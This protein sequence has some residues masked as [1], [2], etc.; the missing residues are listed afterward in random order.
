MK[1][2]DTTTHADYLAHLNRYAT[3]HADNLLIQQSLKEHAKEIV[4]L[5]TLSLDPIRDTLSDLY[6]PTGQGAPRDPTAMF[7]AWLTMTLTK[8]GSPTN[9]VKTTR[10]DPVLATLAGFD[11]LDTP[12]VGTYYDFLARFADGPYDLRRSQDVT[13]S[14]YLRGRHSRRLSDQ[15]TARQEDA[16]DFTSQSEKLSLDLLNTTDRPRDP[17]TL[18]TRLENL[19]VAIGL[20]PTL[21]SGLLKA[22][23]TLTI[24][25]D[26]T[27]LATAAS[28]RGTATCDCEDPKTCDHPKSY[29]S[30]TAQWCY[31][32]SHDRYIFGDRYYTLTLHLNGRDLPLLTL[33]VG[34]NESD[35]TLSLKALDD[36]LKVLRDLHLPLKIGVFVGDGHHDATPIY[37]YLKDKKILPVIPLSKSADTTT[38]P[39]PPTTHPDLRFDED[40]TPLCPAGCRM[41][42]Q[43]FHQAK[44]RHCYACPANH[45]TSKGG[46]FHHVFHA[47]ECPRQTNCYPDTDLGFC[48]T[49]KVDSD[50]RLFPPI[51]RNSKRFKT[52]YN[53]RS[54]TERS[55]SVD[56]SYKLDHRCRNAVYGL[57][58]LTLINVC[59]HAIVRWREQCATHSIDTLLQDTMAVIRAG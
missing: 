32:A 48:V 42:H 35:F 43:G 2:T 19:L 34:G 26:G 18:Q 5:S 13:Q 53:G 24:Q 27:I 22:L 28:P 44:Y 14:Q 40:G 41:R 49:I 20:R 56:D 25:G 10:T 23:D 46:R 1:P 59:K 31:D 37:H 4:I 29:T 47:D 54:S 9:W 3:I 12:G 17:I 30:A 39:H 58:R 38:F 45:A 11:P 15:T 57:I 55:N 8:E 36:L 50:P 52:R 51:P 21:D 7:R 16:K 33:L 6:C